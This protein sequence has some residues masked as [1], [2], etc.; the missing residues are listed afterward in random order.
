VLITPGWL[1]RLLEKVMEM[2]HYDLKDFLCDDAFIR[3]VLAASEADATYWERFLMDNPQSRAAFVQARQIL[4]GL[5]DRESLSAP[6]VE[7][8]KQRIHATLSK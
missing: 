3:Y 4:V 7:A 8:L 5:C 1:F 6:D 2:N